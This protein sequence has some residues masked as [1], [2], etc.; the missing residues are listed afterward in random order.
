M[1]QPDPSTLEAA[2]E[3]L[4]FA[5]PEPLALAEIAQVFP[6]AEPAALEAALRSVEERHEQ[7]GRGLRIAAV[8]GGYRMT[9]RPEHAS[10]LER[11][12][13]ARNRSRLSQA[14]LETLA[15]VA[16]RQPITAPEIQEIRG[17]NC[18]GVLKSLLERRLL[19]ILGRK[20]VVGRPLLYGT[21]RE[22][23]IHFG[24]NSLADLP[25]V[26]E[27]QEV[28]AGSESAPAAAA[29]AGGCEGVA[30]AAV[31]EAAGSE[32]LEAEEAAQALFSEPEREAE[33]EP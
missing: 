1:S 14:A 8:A 32:A 17:V 2:I 21:T 7:P 16:Y 6:D 22:F 18:Q 12:F 27:L 3:A 23:L 4:L 33:G 28:L 19:R 20:P 26:E 13:Q 9:T 25:Q 15:F 10:A 24:L 29:A 11:L 5:S 30:G 31:G